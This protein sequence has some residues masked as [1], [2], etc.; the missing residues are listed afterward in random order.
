MKNKIIPALFA[1]PLLATSASAAITLNGVD[2]IDEDAAVAGVQATR[3]SNELREQNLTITGVGD[4]FTY[5]NAGNSAVIGGNGGGA[6]NTT[7]DVSNGSFIAQGLDNFFLGNSSGDSNVFTVTGGS[8]LFDSNLGIGRDESTGNLL[9]ISGGTVNIT[10]TL[11]FDVPGNVND[12]DDAADG[13]LDFTAGSTGSLTVTGLDAA[14]Y[15]AFYDAGDLTFAGANTETFSDVFQVSG[16]TLSLVAVPEPSSTA[17]LGL[18][19]L[20][21]ILRRRK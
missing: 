19:G 12:L 17:L 14:A 5:D 13:T 15:E 18:G 10:G 20:A 7:I 2:L 16:N 8:V 21:L 9:T 6:F 3:S 4:V 11:S 1:L